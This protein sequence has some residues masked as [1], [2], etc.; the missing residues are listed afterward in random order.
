M[1][2]LWMLQVRVSRVPWTET[3]GWLSPGATRPV[4]PKHCGIVSG[5]GALNTEFE[6]ASVSALCP[7]PSR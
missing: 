1:R 4:D 5:P 3:R 2:P 7:R 6:S